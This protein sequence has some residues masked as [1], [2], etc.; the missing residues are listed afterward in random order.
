M[1]PD[2]N[3]VLIGT[4]KIINF[5]KSNAINFRLSSILSDEE[6][7]FEHLNNFM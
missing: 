2:L 1:S 5:I 3:D 4:V 7:E 6:M